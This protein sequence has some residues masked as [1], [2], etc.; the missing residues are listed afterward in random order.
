[1]SDLKGKFIIEVKLKE[2][3]SYMTV[4][5]YMN[6]LFNEIKDSG[7]QMEFYSIERVHTKIPYP[8][9]TSTSRAREIEL[10]ALQRYFEYD[11]GLSQLRPLWDLLTN[12]EKSEY[13][14]AMEE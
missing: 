5:E 1:M 14:E 9:D 10:L 3:H 4:E 2:E 12:D 11:G 7:D 8:R 6:E 13:F